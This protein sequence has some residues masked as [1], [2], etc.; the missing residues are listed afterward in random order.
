MKLYVEEKQ[1]QDKQTGETVNYSQV[2]LDVDGER[3]PIKA[4]FKNDSRL[5]RSLARNGKEE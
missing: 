3:I 1:F 2:V 4:T 5:L